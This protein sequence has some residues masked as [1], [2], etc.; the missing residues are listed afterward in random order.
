MLPRF[1]K[2]LQASSLFS[3]ELDVVAKVRLL[4]RWLVAAVVREQ[5]HVPV[6]A[7]EGSGSAFETENWF[8]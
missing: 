6:V 1:F 2:A 7:G 3:E 8:G 5:L 4:W